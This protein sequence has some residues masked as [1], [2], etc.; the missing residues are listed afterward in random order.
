MKRRQFLTTTALT[1][2]SFSLIPRKVVS[3]NFPLIKPPHL[4]PGDGVGIISPAGATFKEDDLNMVIEAVKALKLVPKVGQYAL[5]RY[6][7]LAGKDRERAS[8]I[9]QFFAD[10]N[11][12]LILPIRGGWGS[13]RLL[14]YLDYD[15]IRRH[16]K[17][18]CGFSDIT[19]LLLAIYAKTGLVTFHAPNGFSS[20]RT[21]QTESFRQVLFSGE[22]LTFRNL[23]D[24]DDANRLMQV[25][26]RIQTITKGQAKGKLIGGNLTTLASIVGSPYLPDFTGAILFLEDIGED[27][28]EIDRLL[29]QL[30]LAGIFYNLAGFIFG[31]CSNCSA[32]SDYGSL[33]LEEVIREYIQPLKIP[34]CLGLMIGHLEIIETIPI[35]IAVEFDAN[36]GTITMLE[37]AVSK[38]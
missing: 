23:P 6:G 33:T 19:S 10:D 24:P 21:A 28:Y 30:K 16:P 29:N 36:R 3:N 32:N 14:P 1:A 8:D 18:I 15:L 13:A 11:I 2:V 35:G 38:P 31:Q 9:N 17:I 37:S 34:A 5:D 25:K 20:W 12:A 4:Q 26:N 7:Y 22:K 27:I